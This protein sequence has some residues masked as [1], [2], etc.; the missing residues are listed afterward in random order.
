MSALQM[1]RALG[2]EVALSGDKVKL[3]GL[4]RLDHET[5]THAI[6]VARA[7]RDQ[8]WRELAREGADLDAPANYKNSTLKSALPSREACQGQGC[9]AWL[10]GGRDDPACAWRC[11]GSIVHG[12][13][14]PEDAPKPRLAD[15]DACP[16]GRLDGTGLDEWPEHP[17]E[18]VEGD[19]FAA[20]EAAGSLLDL[21]R[22]HGL[23]VEV[24][25]GKARIVY[26]ENAP[27]ALVEYAEQL[28]AEGW[29]FIQA[30][31]GVA[32]TEVHQ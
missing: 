8:L 1:V 31:L 26:P 13:A 11:I 12:G 19:A 9:A 5:A 27:P 10:S 32:P 21:A 20:Y 25:D 18:G 14:D 4:D 22:R 30:M 6:E 29:A 24:T 2:V 7:H 23:R 28:I 17:P 16:F 15:L 3:R